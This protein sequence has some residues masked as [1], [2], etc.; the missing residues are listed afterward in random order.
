MG[1]ASPVME[2]LNSRHSVQANVI[3][4]WGIVCG[5]E[6]LRQDMNSGVEETAIAFLERMNYRL[7]DCGLCV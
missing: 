2:R 5:C 3:V 4:R 1:A 7:D 6:P